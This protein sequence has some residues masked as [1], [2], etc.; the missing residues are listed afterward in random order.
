MA[1]GAREA[2]LLGGITAAACH[3]ALVS[4][5]RHLITDICLTWRMYLLATGIPCKGITSCVAYAGDCLWRCGGLSRSCA[6]GPG[7]HTRLAVGYPCASPNVARL[8]YVA[9]DRRRVTS[10]CVMVSNTP[11]CCGGWRNLILS[12]LLPLDVAS[13]SL[14]PL[15]QLTRLPRLFATLQQRP[16]LY[17]TH[18]PAPLFRMMCR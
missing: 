5:A 13:P 6:D 11:F 17:L 12:Q 9:M 8:R 1:K 4:P 15:T 10:M 14:P 3:C 2:I 16:T 18:A 7:V